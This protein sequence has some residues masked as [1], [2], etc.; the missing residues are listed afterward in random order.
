[1]RIIL[2]ESCLCKGLFDLSPF[3]VKFEIEQWRLVKANL[4]VMTAFISD[5]KNRLFVGDKINVN[6]YIGT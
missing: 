1:M 6:Q 5:W 2:F 3:K 4:L